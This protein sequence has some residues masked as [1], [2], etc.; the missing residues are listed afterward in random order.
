MFGILLVKTILNSVRQRSV[1]NTLK[2]T[3]FESSKKA[4][5]TVDTYPDIVFYR[6]KSFEDKLARTLNDRSLALDINTSIFEGELI[7]SDENKDYLFRRESQK[8][9][10]SNCFLHKGER[11][12]SRNLFISAEGQMNFLFPSRDVSSRLG[13]P[14]EIVCRL[15][16]I[17]SDILK[18][19]S[20]DMSQFAAT[21]SGKMEPTGCQ[22]R[23][24]SGEDVQ[25]HRLL[26]DV[27][28]PQAL[29]IRKKVRL[30]NGYFYA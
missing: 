29:K 12:V 11:V 6:N 26:L 28:R 27:G 24:K 7:L 30:S 22:L 21:S 5:F 15:M 17:S 2:N 1:I 25:R 20:Q 8:E 4:C 3:I 13:L 19:H 23:T 10:E 16:S 9:T 14:Q 18:I